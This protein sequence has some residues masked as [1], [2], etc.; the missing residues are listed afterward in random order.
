MQKVAKMFKSLT[1]YDVLYIILT[2]AT[3]ILAVVHARTDFID[4]NGLYMPFA[5]NAYQGNIDLLYRPIPI[6]NAQG[7]WFPYIYTWFF[8]FMMVPFF[9]LGVVGKYIFAALLFYS[10]YLVINFSYECAT[11]FIPGA[12]SKK[13]IILSSTILLTLYPYS[14][15]LKNAN[16]GIFLVLFSLL[17]FKLRKSMPLLA[18]VCLFLVF[19]I[20]YYGLIILGYFFWLKEWRVV[21]YSILIAIGILFVLPVIAFGYLPTS[22]MYHDF[23][24]AIN[25]YGDGWSIY[26]IVYPNVV[27]PALR[28][29]NYLGIDYSHYRTSALAIL[30]VCATIIMIWFLPSFLR[31]KDKITEQYRLRMFLVSLCLCSMLSPISWYNMVLFYTPLVIFGLIDLIILKNTYSKIGITAYLLLF[32]LTTPSF[33]GNKTNDLLEFYAVPFAGLFILFICFVI[34]TKK[35]KLT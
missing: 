33:V 23:F 35:D 28:F 5:A 16:I 3:F 19:G 24:I 17:A 15:V 29:L 12:D 2:F 11:R 32:A 6:G 8:A 18:S 1:K 10:Y 20:K 25:G 13:K 22:L 31:K 4:Y 30:L 34:R 26:S 21:L 9:L 7:F 14:D 27:S